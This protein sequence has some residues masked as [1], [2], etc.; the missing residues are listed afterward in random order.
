MESAAEERM[1]SFFHVQEW[2]LQVWK[3]KEKLI[4]F[5]SLTLIY[6]IL[7]E[8]NRSSVTVFIIITLGKEN[9]SWLCATGRET[10]EVPWQVCLSSASA[11]LFCTLSCIPVILLHAHLTWWTC[12]ANS[13]G[14]GRTGRGGCLFWITKQKI[15]APLIQSRSSFSSPSLIIIII[16]KERKWMAQWCDPVSRWI[17]GSEHRGERGLAQSSGLTWILY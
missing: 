12:L 16:C 13:P 11:V 15:L 3:Q 14:G 1:D 7:D 6:T 5:F 2:Q 8:D 9:L 17:S 10:R 4:G